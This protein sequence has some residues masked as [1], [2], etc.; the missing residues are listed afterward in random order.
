MNYYKTHL[1]FEIKNTLYDPIQSQLIKFSG[2]LYLPLLHSQLQKLILHINQNNFT[3]TFEKLIILNTDQINSQ[4]YNLL[5]SLI[6]KN[7]Y[8]ANNQYLPLF[9]IIQYIE[10]II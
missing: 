1:Y 5:V 4:Y 2:T 7:N 8:V 9:Y 10:N 6:D 3:H